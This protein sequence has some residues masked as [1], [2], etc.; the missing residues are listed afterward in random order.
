[1]IIYLDTE[2]SGLRPGNIC[3]LSY[4]KQYKD[5]VEPVNLFFKVSYVEMSACAVHHF[6]VELL[7]K[8]SG[9]KTFKDYAKKIA[10]DFDSADLI[11]A[12]NID[13]DFSFLRK[14]FE[15][16]GVEFKYNETFCSMKKFTPVCRLCRSS[17]KGYKYP[18]LNELCAYFN[19]TDKDV[20]QE[21]SALFNE[22]LLF[23]DARYDTTAVFLAVNKA[24]NTLPDFEFLMEKL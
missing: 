17:S 4:I 23:H 7:K 12:H 11:C 13:F 9:G 15:S 10:K 18:K 21:T 2:T 16:V 19:I 1:M 24:M 3:Q 6:S 14:E 20:E 5:R 8:L 22:S